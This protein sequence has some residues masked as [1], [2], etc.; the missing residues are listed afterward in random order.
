MGAV[1]ALLELLVSF[2][3]EAIYIADRLPKGWGELSSGRIRTA[4]GF[5][6]SGVIRKYRNDELTITCTRSGTLDII[7]SLGKTWMLDGV[8][9]D[10][11]RLVLRVEAM[12]S[13]QLR[14]VI[15]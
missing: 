14:R 9:H 4:G 3:D 13:Y 15:V 10:E 5:V 12:Q 6:V 2:R 11:A 1:S 7:H 8:H